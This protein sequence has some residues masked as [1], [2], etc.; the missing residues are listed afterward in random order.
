MSTDSHDSIVISVLIDSKDIENFL[1]TKTKKRGCEHPTPIE[2]IKFCP[3]CG[4]IAWVESHTIFFDDVIRELG[5]SSAQTENQDFVVS[6]SAYVSEILNLSY[7]QNIVQ[8]SIPP[9]DD[10]VKLKELL[11]S[12]LE[13]IGLWKESNFDI[14]LVGYTG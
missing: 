8:M 2:T 14:W 4:K 3:E 12:K 10:I 6:A 5:L 13:P 7:G 1:S 11:R 9:E